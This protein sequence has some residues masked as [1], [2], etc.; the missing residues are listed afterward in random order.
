[1]IVCGAAPAHR[2]RVRVLLL[3]RATHLV[4]P[5]PGPALA[6]CLQPVLTF[7]DGKFCPDQQP[8]WSGHRDPSFGHGEP[9]Q[10]RGRTADGSALPRGSALVCGGLAGS[11][12][13]LLEKRP[14]PTFN[15]PH[16]PLQPTAPTQTHTH[17]HNLACPALCPP[18]H[19]RHAHHPQRHA[20][21]V[22]LVPQSRWGLGAARPCL[23]HQKP[24]LRTGAAAEGVFSR[25]VD[26]P[27]VRAGVRERGLLLF[28]RRQRCI[29]AA[30]GARQGVLLAAGRTRCRHAACTCAELTAELN[31]PL[32]CFIKS[33]PFWSALRTAGVCRSLRS[34]SIDLSVGVVRSCTCWDLHAQVTAHAVGNLSLDPLPADQGRV[35][36]Q[37]A[38]YTLT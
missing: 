38:P 29:V 28:E 36:I 5:C 11:R 3:N 14:H 6:C 37:T 22:G 15:L 27:A 19:T 30:A 4:F 8:E 26:H 32:A 20:R 34:C 10:P 7:Q 12:L 33:L 16:P 9:L 35:A 31:F 13:C 21:R 2:R 18:P 17:T 1:M 23:H 25:W 24:R